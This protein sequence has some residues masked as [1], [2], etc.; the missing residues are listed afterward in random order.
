MQ[1]EDFNGMQRLSLGITQSVVMRTYP[2]QFGTW[3]DTF[4]GPDKP[5]TGSFL[6]TSFK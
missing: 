4:E 6:R 1:I 5:F 2:L 3:S